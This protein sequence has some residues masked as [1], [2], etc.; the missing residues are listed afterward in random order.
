[1]TPTFQTALTLR[2]AGVS[3]IH[4]NAD[5][6]P[7]IQWKQYQSQLPSEA[8]LATWFAGD[9]GI[10]VVA[11][12][13][14][15]IDFDCKYAPDIFRRFCARSQEVGLDGIVASLARQR[16]PSGGYHLVMRCDDASV[17]NEK[18]AS[19]PATD[20]ERAANPHVREFTMI[21]TRGDGGYFLV[22]PSPGYHLE[23]GD[24]SSIPNI[25]TEDRDALLD[26][27]RSFDERA[28]VEVVRQDPRTPSYSAPGQTPGDAYDQQADVPA[29]LSAHGWQHARGC[30][31]TRPGKTRGISASWDHEG[32]GRFIVFTTSSEFDPG[33]SYKPWHVF[34]IL[35]CGGDWARAAG[36]LRR[37][38]FGASRPTSHVLGDCSPLSVPFAG[39][40]P[41]Q[42]DPLG[43]EGT[44]PADLS[45]EPSVNDGARPKTAP[46]TL[47]NPN[48]FLDYTVDPNDAL[49]DGYFVAKR[50]WTTLIG[51]GGLGK[52]RL[53]L[54]LSI[55]MLTGRPWC[56]LAVKGKPGRILF[57]S[58]E[59]GLRRWKADLE[60]I[61]T[62]LSEAEKAVVNENLFILALTPEESGDLSLGDGE[63]VAKLLATIE[64]VQP[65][66]IIC[67]PFASMVDGDENSTADMLRTIKT[68]D[69]VHH[70]GAPA[71][72]MI[73]IHHART[74]AQNIL[75]AGDNFNAGNSGRGSKALYSRARC[76]LQL[77]PGDRED[78][79]K[80]VLC[81]GK[82]NDGEK[83]RPR[84]IVFDPSTFTYAVDPSFNYDAW[85]AD[86]AGKNNG[87]SCSVM[88]VVH[89]V[90]EILAG[91][92][93][94]A[95]ASCIIEAVHENTGA[96]T[97]AINSRVNDAV[98]G[99]YLRR[100][101]QG[102]YALGEKRLPRAA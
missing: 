41:G 66:L 12:T 54:W 40:E 33:H 89:A 71:S 80:L 92:V 91:G 101:R 46:F 8:E 94:F 70:R 24:W 96:S 81:C 90:R 34:A 43:V 83:F 39:G 99:G 77:V 98:R 9:A 26:L 16:T 97:R 32:N 61:F 102:V 42:D 100:I 6:R 55:C 49:L 67:D 79:T 52:T 13:I 44:E 15:C 27:A 28:P 18:L 37:Q 19:R 29:L 84:G 76:E 22:D 31:W 2:A 36:E 82:N 63:N 56:G 69:D 75:Q 59:N 25:S 87:Q 60:K 93:E 10:A 20:Q 5:K 64:S 4:V 14:L 74:G 88:D 50:S 48:Q 3:T 47:W 45:V 11:G 65:G 73:I 86:V 95:R 57:L 30:Y 38:G 85:R 23:H 17:A 58:S 7:R 72:A 62:V 68:L 78:S 35:E 21:E 53:L 51:I 1:M